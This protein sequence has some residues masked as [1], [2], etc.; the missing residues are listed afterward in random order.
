M[1]AFCRHNKYTMDKSILL[2][3]YLFFLAILSLLLSL[4]LTDY[5]ED[6]ARSLNI[7]LKVNI[8]YIANCLAV[9]SHTLYTSTTYTHHGQ[10]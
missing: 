5:A 8:S 4:L 7:L 9:T 2:L 10:L 1:P 6:F 3:F